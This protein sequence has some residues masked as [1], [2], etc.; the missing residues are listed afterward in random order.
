MLK[1]LFVIPSLEYGGA[2]KQLTLLATHL[3]RDRFQVQVCILKEGGAWQAKL[4]SGHIPCE[5]LNWTRLVDPGALFRLRKSIKNFRPHIIH[6]WT[7]PAWR[8]V[9]AASLGIN[10]AIVVSNCLSESKPSLGSKLA[11]QGLLA[12]TKKVVAF[13]ESEAGQYPTC[14]IRCAQIVSVPLGVETDEKAY[15]NS[16]ELRDELG[17]APD[18]KLLGCVGPL[19]M[20]KGCHEAIWALD[21]L[22]FL[23]NNLHLVIIG[24]GPDL[25]RLKSFAQATAGSERVHFL[26]PRQNVPRLLAEIDLAWIPSLSDTGRNFMLEAMAAGKPFVASCWPGLKELVPD[27]LKEC[28]VQAGDKAAFARQTRRLLDDASLCDRLGE[29]GRRH[30][31]DCFSVTA[32]S[33]NFAN[34]YESIDH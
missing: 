4:E 32:L 2:A 1:V 23:Y 14:G 28:L 3:P 33:N 29:I 15:S 22:H 25:P 16:R 18:A 11:N 17:L 21:I 20:N 13:G 34:L 27:E 19:T 31:Q 30:V 24:D 6:A 5:I 12:M 26:G 9:W 10:T 7:R 8:A